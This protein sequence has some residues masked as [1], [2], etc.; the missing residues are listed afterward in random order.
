MLQNGDSSSEVFKTKSGGDQI[1]RYANV[2]IIVPA[3][4]Q[5]ERKFKKQVYASIP[6]R[7]GI[8]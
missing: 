8:S 2:P 7:Y 1:L 3:Q 4:I 6:M 5:E